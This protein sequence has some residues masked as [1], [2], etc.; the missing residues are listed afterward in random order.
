MAPGADSHITRVVIVLFRVKDTVLVSPNGLKPQKFYSESFCVSSR[1]LTTSFPGSVTVRW[2]SLGTWLGYCAEKNT[3][4]DFDVYSVALENPSLRSWRYCRRA[5]LSFGSGDP[6][7]VSAEAARNFS[8]SFPSQLSPLTHEAASPRKLYSA[9]LQYC[10][11]VIK[12]I[13]Q[14]MHVY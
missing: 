10:L 12:I 9:R 5:E 6:I 2:E 3:T 4:V 1:V 14:C 7:I 8:S 11:L 13:W